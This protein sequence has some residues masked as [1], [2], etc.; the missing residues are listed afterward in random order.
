LAEIN[1][2]K[3][4][5]EKGRI[6]F[7]NTKLEPAPGGVSF[8]KGSPTKKRRPPRVKTITICPYCNT[9]LGRTTK[10]ERCGHMRINHESKLNEILNKVKASKIDE[11][12]EK[13]IDP[14][15]WAAGKAYKAGMYA[16]N[17]RE[18]KVNGK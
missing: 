12:R 8:R 9:L 18:G 11:L 6:E 3:D 15:C 14:F 5:D 1:R 16:N 13:G 2:D 10:Q 4:R 17:V 7:R